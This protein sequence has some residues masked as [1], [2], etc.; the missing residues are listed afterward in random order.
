MI[1]EKAVTREVWDHAPAHQLRKP[2]HLTQHKAPYLNFTNQE[3]GA[4]PAY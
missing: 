2:P 1:D 3:F 4:Q